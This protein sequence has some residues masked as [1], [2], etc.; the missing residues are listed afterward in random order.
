MSTNTVSTD[1]PSVVPV[2]EEIDPSTE[3]LEPGPEEEEEEE[4]EVQQ[5]VEEAV[6]ETAGTPSFNDPSGIARWLESEGP[7]GLFH[8]AWDWTSH[9]IDDPAKLGD[10]ASWEH[11]FD[12]HI[13]SFDDAASFA[14]EMLAS[15]N[16]HVATI[17]YG[18]G[19]SYLLALEEGFFLGTGMVFAPDRTDQHLLL[20]DAHNSLLPEFDKNGFPVVT[21]VIQ[22]SPAASAGIRAG[23]SCRK[24]NGISTQGQS[25]SW[26]N[27]RINGSDGAC[28]LVKVRRN[29]SNSKYRSR[30]HKLTQSKTALNNYHKRLGNIGYIRLESFFDSNTDKQVA[31]A[32]TE[33]ADCAGFIID[34]RGTPGGRTDK[35]AQV[36]SLFL[37]QGKICRVEGRSV[38]GE[39]ILT[40]TEISMYREPSDYVTYERH[41]NLTGDKPVVILISPNTRSAPEVFT[42]ALKEHGRVTVLGEP[43]FGKGIAG[44][45][46]RIGSQAMIEIPMAR[47]YT[48]SGKWI[49]DAAQTCHFGLYPDIEVKANRNIVFGGRNDNQLKAARAL[50]KEH[51]IK[52][53]NITRPKIT[54]VPK[55]H[56]HSLVDMNT[57]SPWGVDLS[58]FNGTVDWNTLKQQGPAFTFIKA[59]EGATIVDTSFAENWSAAKGKGII[60]SP[61]HFFAPKTSTVQAQIDNF[62]TTI[63]K[64][65]VG[66]LPPVLDVES[67]APTSWEGLSQQA[68]AD[69]VIAWLEG[70]KQR[71]G[72]S[73]ILYLSPNFCEEVLGNDPRLAD[74]ILWLA[75]YTTD[76]TPI[77]PKPFTAWT[78]WQYTKTGNVKG[79]VGDVDIDRFNGDSAGLETLR[80]K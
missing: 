46:L 17:H 13:H 2:L 74:W 57:N 40:E 42:A 69:L 59:T 12:D 78:F 39:Y 80:I 34:V 50:I 11:R 54:G 24:I 73:P 75:L 4:E 45:L 53:V 16:D 77:I 26:L 55:L 21:W 8:L 6:Q 31:R 61:Y 1:I 62:C 64:L 71:L 18:P 20:K 47:W 43:S 15:I 19:Q 44:T 38:S 35:M 79:V 63:G 29:Y 48:S 23:D 27:L 76:P 28:L 60:R 10:W 37:D 58:Q 7:R 66:D 3:E 32:L 51:I 67:H 30:N 68:A 56:F 33:L 52:Q 65:E 72:V 5:V 70:V 22:G 36:V 9:Y 49:G 25:I 14:T 41:P